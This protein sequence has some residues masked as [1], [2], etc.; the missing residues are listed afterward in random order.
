CFNY[1]SNNTDALCMKINTAGDTLWTKVF[2]SLAN[3]NDNAF[4][5]IQTVDSGYAIAGITQQTTVPYYQ[6]FL[7]K[8][9]GAGNHQWTKIL[10]A[11]N[12]N[13]GV[14]SIIQTADS[15]FAMVQGT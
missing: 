2:H 5:V 15:G 10:S 12:T 14:P 7:T 13:F 11:V 6:I 4:S 3:T 1:T 9:D 8:T